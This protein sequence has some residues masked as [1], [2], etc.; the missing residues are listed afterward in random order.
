MTAC[1]VAPDLGLFA[2]CEAG[3]CRGGCYSDE[4]HFNQCNCAQIWGGCK[5]PYVCCLGFGCKTEDECR[6]GGP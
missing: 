1:G 4:M 6:A 2:C 3:S 5:P